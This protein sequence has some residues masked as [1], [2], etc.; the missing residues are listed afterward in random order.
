[1]I[2]AKQR[3][4]YFAPLAGR[5]YQSLTAACHAQARARIRTKFPVIQERETGYWESLAESDP[6]RYERLL[7]RLERCYRRQFRAAGELI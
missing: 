4:V 6:E 7:K 5:H 1:V 3:I 2:Q